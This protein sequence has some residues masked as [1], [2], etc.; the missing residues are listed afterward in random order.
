LAVACQVKCENI[1]V[2][3]VVEFY[4]II[5]VKSIKDDE[6]GTPDIFSYK[7]SINHGYKWRRNSMDWPEKGTGSG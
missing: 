3:K 4:S 2:P 7:T 1:N 5:T 6:R